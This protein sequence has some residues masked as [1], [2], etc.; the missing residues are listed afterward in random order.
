MKI[1]SKE[2]VIK[3]LTA[4]MINPKKKYS[5]NFLTD[6]E[7]VKES[8]NSLNLGEDEVVVEI[9]IAEPIF[10]ICYLTC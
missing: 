4:L 10:I 6:Y 9:G 8:V 7:T 5:Q 1:A 2:Y 3:K